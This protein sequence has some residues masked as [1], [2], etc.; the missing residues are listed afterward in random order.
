MDDFKHDMWANRMI[1]IFLGITVIL[2]LVM[3]S[4]LSIAGKPAPE[5]MTAIGTAAL[6]ALSA[7][8]TRVGIA[9]PSSSEDT[10]FSKTQSKIKIVEK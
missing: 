10:E 4:A 1:I 7:I 9:V 8:L 5:G 2:T 6:G 3:W